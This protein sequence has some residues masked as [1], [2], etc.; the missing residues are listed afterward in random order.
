MQ[1]IV[2][3]KNAIELGVS[4]EA[5]VYQ[6]SERRFCIST[7]AAWEAGLAAAGIWVDHRY[8]QSVYDPDRA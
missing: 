4:C 7:E 5:P 2:G 8:M 6:I 1:I 3:K